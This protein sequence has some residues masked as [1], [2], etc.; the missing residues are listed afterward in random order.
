MNYQI[1]N[2]LGEELIPSISQEDLDAMKEV[3]E[4]NLFQ[5]DDNPESHIVEGIRKYK[6]E[7]PTLDLE[8]IRLYKEIEE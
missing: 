2:Y 4:L 6:E 3:V 1:L 8:T 5:W 7:H